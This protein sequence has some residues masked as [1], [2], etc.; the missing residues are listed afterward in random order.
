MS[1]M[2]IFKTL[3]PL[4]LL[5]QLGGSCK[6]KY[7]DALPAVTLVSVTMHSLDTV[8]ITGRIASEGAAAVEYAG[9][10]FSEKANAS[11]LTN[12][13]LVPVASTF[14]AY[15]HAYHD[16]TYYFKAFAANDYGYTISNVIKLKIS[17]PGPATAPCPLVSNQVTD[18]GMTF[19]VFA[20]GSA[21]N[22]HYGNYTVSIYGSNEDIYVS[23]PSVPYNGI[24]TTTTNSSGPGAGQCVVEIIRFN[25]YIVND[26][27]KVYVAID[28]TGKTTLSTCGL[29]Y[30]IGSGT[31]T[32]YGKI[33]Y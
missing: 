9:F 3:L 12:Q 18:N 25:Q 29:N 30:N 26:N 33:T 20:L 14:T 6:K 28:S 23:F 5:A 1:L 22:P 27:Q 16:S 21:S 15:A 17:T 10:S 7:D 32:M 31:A 13:V 11:I 2:R 4:V 24:Y 8:L 19:P